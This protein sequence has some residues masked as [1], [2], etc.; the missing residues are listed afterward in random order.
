MLQLSP[1]AAGEK[2]IRALDLATFGKLLDDRLNSEGKVRD[3]LLIACFLNCGLK[4]SLEALVAED[5]DRSEDMLRKGID[6]VNREALGI[7]ESA[8]DEIS[9]LLH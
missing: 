8:K 1:K 5:I 6:V 4:D 3:E 9:K 7:G 2:S